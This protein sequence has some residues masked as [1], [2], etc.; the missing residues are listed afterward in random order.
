ML[1]EADQLKFENIYKSYPTTCL[2]SLPP[3]LPSTAT[4]PSNENE[5]A[6][7]VKKGVFNKLK[8]KNTIINFTH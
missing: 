3:T 8:N 7:Y 1:L 6:I 2:D 5:N 4:I